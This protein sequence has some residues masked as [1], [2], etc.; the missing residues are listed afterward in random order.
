MKTT[1][2]TLAVL[3]IALVVINVYSLVAH[4]LLSLI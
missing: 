1:F 2:I 4:Y 3:G